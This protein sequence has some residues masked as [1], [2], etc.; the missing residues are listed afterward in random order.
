LDKALSALLRVDTQLQSD[1]ANIGLLNFLDKSLSLTG[2]QAVVTGLQST[3]VVSPVVADMT[4]MLRWKL[5]FD[6][7]NSFAEVRSSTHRVLVTWG[8]PTGYHANPG[9]T[10]RR[11]QR[12]VRIVQGK[13][14]PSDIALQTASDIRTTVGFDLNNNINDLQGNHWQL[15][16]ADSPARCDCIS[17]AVFAVKHLRMLGM[18]S[19]KEGVAWATGGNPAGDTDVTAQESDNS[20]TPRPLVFFAAGGAN[21]FEGFFEINEGGP[22][23]AFTVDPLAGPI[24]EYVGAVAGDKLAYNVLKTTLQ[25]ISSNSTD[26]RAGKQ[27]WF[28]GPNADP[29]TG[30]DFTV[31]I[32][33]PAPNN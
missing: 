4:A 25:L 18:S 27:F 1:A 11:V 33:F 8:T 32:P 10:A 22:R 15:L 31:E 3:T 12:A 13:V 23:Q 30:I 9:V 19:A 21:N 26:P 2:S 5:S 14:D 24:L 20:S 28:G 6:G 29:V 7:G 16:D 17:L